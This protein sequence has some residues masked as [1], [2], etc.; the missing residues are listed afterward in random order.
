MPDK[1]KWDEESSR[2]LYTLKNEKGLT[3]SEIAKKM[4]LRRLQCESKYRQTNWK[5]FF[6]NPTQRAYEEWSDQES[7]ELYELKK[8][9]IPASQIAKKLGRSLASIKLKWSNTNWERSLKEI[10]NNKKNGH[11]TKE[12]VDEIYI[13]Q[14]VVA[15]IEIAR[16]EPDRLQKVTKKQFYDKTV[17][18][19]KNLPISFTELKRKALYQ[20][21]QIGFCY[22]SSELLG[23]GTYIIV[24]DCHGKHT[25]T[26]MFKLLSRLNFHLDATAIIHVGH[27]IDDDNDANYNWDKFDNLHI[28]A[29]V[30]ELKVLAKANLKHKIIRREL[31][32]GKHLSVQNQDLVTD[33]VKTFIGSAITPEYFKEST[34]C[35]LHRHEFDTR[36][37]EEGV[38]SFVAS[39]GC[40]CESHIVYTIKQQDFTDGRTVKQTFPTGYKKYRRMEHQLKTWEQGFLVVHVS[41]D[42]EAAPPIQCRVHQTSKGFTTSYFN[43]IITEKKILEPHEKTFVNADLHADHHDSKVL[44][45]QEQV[46]KDY[47]PD[48]YVNL[49]DMNENE[50][51]NHHI[52][53]KNGSMRLDKSILEESATTNF[54]LTRM[55]QWAKKTYLLKGNHERFYV[56]FI[57][58]FP[59]FSELLDF[60]FINGI[61]DLDIEIINLK[62]NKRIGNVNYV[63]GEMILY[64]Q[65]GSHKLDKMFRT[66]GPNTVMG[67]CHYPSTRSGCY[68]VGLSGQLD[69]K[70]NEANASKWLHGFAYCNSFEDK[71]FISNVCIVDNKCIVND[72]IYEPASDDDWIVPKFKAKIHF[73]Y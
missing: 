60:K 46:C 27:F 58:K 12:M 31:L 53:K 23:P 71:V 15:L 67:H 2:L 59:Q 21:E 47:K 41:E 42:G 49:G 44:S 11:K 48:N 64:G 6:K 56:D 55:N 26:G 57:N 10:S 34:I 18:P 30:E 52:F 69:L 16:H 70:Y 24:G 37:T 40:M 65:R 22:P 20:L 13:D 63:H 1:F 50:S 36:C 68:T 4:G 66:Y 3:F 8:L 14:L 32:L 25:R 61:N 19:S 35:N 38:N 51:I 17:L 5:K 43:K 29:K 73:E 45:I 39:P 33:Y 9:K 54:L 28:I 72:K 7:I 62:Q